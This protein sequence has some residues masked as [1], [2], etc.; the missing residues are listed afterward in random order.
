[1]S[2]RPNLERAAIVAAGLLALALSAPASAEPLRPAAFNASVSRGDYDTAIV[3]YRPISKRIP[4]LPS[5]VR[6]MAFTVSPDRTVIRASGRIAPRTPVVFH[7][8]VVSRRL[9][10]TGATVE[11]DSTGGSQIAG[12]M[13]GLAIRH[14]GLR[15]ALSGKCYSACALAFIGGTVRTFRSGE[16][17][18]IHQ[19][20]RFVGTTPKPVPA[21]RLVL[22]Y[23]ERMGIDR[24]MQDAAD[25]VPFT[26]MRHVSLEEAERWRISTAPRDR[27]IAQ[28]LEDVDAFVA[29]NY[30]QAAPPSQPDFAM[31]R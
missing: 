19:A 24:A 8:F 14:F 1:M 15:T 3:L 26:T 28:M 17:F 4:K 30:P 11:I 6:E 29:S 22:S 5:P 2:V 31:E 27:V 13:L 9:A 18:G 16:R 20:Y 10:G 7:T 12:V 21:N 25:A 23:V